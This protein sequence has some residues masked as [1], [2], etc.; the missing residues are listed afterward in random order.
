MQCGTREVNF[1]AVWTATVIISAYCR[2]AVESSVRAKN[3]CM[4]TGFDSGSRS[5]QVSKALAETKYFLWWIS[6][7]RILALKRAGYCTGIRTGLPSRYNFRHAIAS[8]SGV[9]LKLYPF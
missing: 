9:S 2:N 7:K 1:L 5:N 3:H 8:P 4:I 6:D